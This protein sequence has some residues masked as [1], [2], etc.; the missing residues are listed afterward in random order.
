M[1][2][3]SASQPEHA[4]LSETS[5]AAESTTAT[6]STPAAVSATEPKPR[7]IWDLAVSIIL[8]VV[9][10]IV[11]VLMLV[12][13]IFLPM[14]SAG[15]GEGCN[16][17]Q[18]QLGMVLAFVSPSVLMLVASII[19]IV[20]IV[21]RKLSFWVV[22]LGLVL[23]IVAWFLSIIMVFSASPSFQLGDVFNTLS[24]LNS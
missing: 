12:P 10:A 17:D 20:L 2:D 24:H 14:V 6:E 21:Q 13:S 5:V 16:A 23:A 1:T 11:V 9:G 3:T 7:R 8:M 22:L 15:C 18:M 4:P 19:G